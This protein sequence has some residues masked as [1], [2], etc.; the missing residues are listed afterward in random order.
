MSFGEAVK[1]WVAR[2]VVHNAIPVAFLLVVLLAI[3]LDRRRNTP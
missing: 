3:Y 2:G 1:F